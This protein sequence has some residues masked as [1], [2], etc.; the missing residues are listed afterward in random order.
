[1]SNLYT[2]L[3]LAVFY[4]IRQGQKN[5]VNHATKNMWSLSGPSNHLINRNVTAQ[6]M[7]RRKHQ[8]TN[9]RKHQIKQPGVDVQRKNIYRKGRN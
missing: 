9:R 5:L 2:T 1:M 8:I 4:V 7:N 3:T 6:S